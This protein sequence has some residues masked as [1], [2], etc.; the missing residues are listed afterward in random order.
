MPDIRWNLL[1]NERLK[2]TRGASFEDVLKGKLI[3]IKNTL[4]EKAKTLC[5]LNTN[6][7]YGSFPML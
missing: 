3:A 6:V 4:Q 2:K 1:K 7:M 5:Y